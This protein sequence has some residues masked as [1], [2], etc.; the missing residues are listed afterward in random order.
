MSIAGN[1]RKREERE[2]T[3]RSSSSGRV[4][5]RGTHRVALWG[6]LQNPKFQDPIPMRGTSLFVLVRWRRLTIGIRVLGFG[7][8]DLRMNGAERLEFDGALPRRR[9]AG[10]NNSDHDREVQHADDAHLHRGRARL[11][12]KCR[13]HVDESRA[14]EDQ[15]E[16]RVDAAARERRADGH[17]GGLPA[18]PGLRPFLTDLE[19]PPHTLDT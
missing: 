10:A 7:M 8:W 1:P 18:R 17:R 4:C 15:C 16:E 12:R 5:Y 6:T 14:G 11:Q 13:D 19:D 9:P 2:R 3:P